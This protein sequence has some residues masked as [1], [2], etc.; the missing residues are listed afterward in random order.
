MFQ[1]FAAAFGIGLDSENAFF[2]Q[3]RH[4][5]RQHA[6]GLQDVEDNHRFHGVQLQLPGLCAQRHGE[7]VADH[8][9]GDL[10]HHFGNDRD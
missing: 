9:I 6:H 10:V 2:P 4:A 7:V 3:H 1:K 8:L 5:A